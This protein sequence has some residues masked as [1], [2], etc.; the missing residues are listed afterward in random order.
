MLPTR[1]STLLRLVYLLLA[2]LTLSF[3]LTPS[4]ASPTKRDVP[5]GH[6]PAHDDG[7]PTGT[8]TNCDCLG[9]EKNDKRDAAHSL[10]NDELANATVSASCN[11]FS[12][13]SWGLRDLADNKSVLYETEG[14]NSTV[15][16]SSCQ[17]AIG[18]MEYNR[19]LGPDLCKVP[20][21]GFKFSSDDC[22]LWFTQAKGKW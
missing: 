21:G 2:L 10:S 12:K 22:K 17:K 3:L 7:P 6:C 11:A 5:A 9:D 19:A 18:W 4:V 13:L 8:M 1:Q 14:C 20:E 16:D 15:Q